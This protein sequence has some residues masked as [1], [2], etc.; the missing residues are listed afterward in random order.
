MRIAK[1]LL[2]GFEGLQITHVPRFKNQMEDAL[3]NLVTSAWHPC[4]VGLS[5][6]DQSFI[7]GT[8]ISTIDHQA[9]QSWMTPITE[10]LRNGVLLE[11]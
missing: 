6:M 1:P 9:K 10:Y 3:A 11:K 8:T 4:N 5:V 2:A 7:L